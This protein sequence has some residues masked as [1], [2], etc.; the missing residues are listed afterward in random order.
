[1]ENS[2]QV[3]ELVE[4]KQAKSTLVENKQ[5][6]PTLDE[7][8]FELVCKFAEKQSSTTMARYTLD[9]AWKYQV[10]INKVKQTLGINSQNLTVLYAK[11]TVMNVAMVLFP[12]T[13]ADMN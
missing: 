1:M 4:K 12:Y 10:A 5:A 3:T 6:E 9:K 13:I 11:L 2:Q 7:D 8:G